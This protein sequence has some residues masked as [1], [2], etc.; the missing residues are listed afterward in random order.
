M[1]PP[2][3]AYEE[4]LIAGSAAVGAI[5]ITNPI[6]VVKTRMQGLKAAEYSSTLDCFVKIATR[7]GPLQLYSGAIAR[8]AR[9][10]PGQGIIFMSQEKIYQA[11]ASATGRG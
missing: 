9:V 11:L 5:C 3:P 8:A 6:D 10:V 4:F 1:A 7:E 2:A